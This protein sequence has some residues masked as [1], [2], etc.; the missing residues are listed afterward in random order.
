MAAQ[1]ALAGRQSANLGYRS[2]SAVL[3]RGCSS[4]HSDMQQV[5]G[6]VLKSRLSFIEE[7]AGANGLTRVLDTLSDDDRSTLKRVLPVGW[8]PFALGERLDDAIVG[9]LGNGDQRFFERLGAASAER[10]LTSVHKSYLRPGDPHGFLERAPAIFRSYYESGRRE[11]ERTGP[12][13]GVLTTYDADAFSLPDCLTII[14]W[15]RTALE[16]C[17]AV[18]VT[19]V[20]TECRARGA[21]VC[22]YTVTWKRATGSQTPTVS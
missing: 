18:Q 10:N 16:M 11:Y 17:G 13:S 5:K 8:Y 2:Q 22:R 15:H 12:T 6:A 1:L 19:I 21:S 9:V 7:H 4:G 20:E 3:P 14:G